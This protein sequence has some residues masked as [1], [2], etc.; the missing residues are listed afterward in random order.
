MEIDIK[1]FKGGLMVYGSTN[2]QNLIKVRCDMCRKF[3]PIET[4]IDRYDPSCEIMG[5]DNKPSP[6]L[7]TF[8]SKAC[9][10][11]YFNENQ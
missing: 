7:R 11:K 2:D 5:W 4:I 9:V 8:C 10:D 6:V 3:A 1:R